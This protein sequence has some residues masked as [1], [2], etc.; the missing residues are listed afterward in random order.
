[1]AVT[2]SL[3]HIFDRLIVGAGPACVVG[4]LAPYNHGVLLAGD[5][6]EK[7]FAGMARSYTHAVVELSWYELIRRDE[8]LEFA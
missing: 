5:A 3:L 6:R 7:M 1:M 8:L 4:A 2:L